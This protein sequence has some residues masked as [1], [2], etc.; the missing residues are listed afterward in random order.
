MRANEIQVR[1]RPDAHRHALSRWKWSSTHTSRIQRPRD[2]RDEQRDDEPYADTRGVGAVGVQRRGVA[3]SRAKS[4]KQPR[5]RVP[6]GVPLP[7]ASSSGESSP[8]SSAARVHDDQICRLA[9]R[10][11]ADAVAGLTQ[12]AASAV[13]LAQGRGAVLH[14][15][16]YTYPSRYT[17]GYPL[18]LEFF[19]RLR[20]GFGPLRVDV[21]FGM[22]SVLFIFMLARGCFSASLLE[23][24]LR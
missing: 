1:A 3:M 15:G 7:R 6:S 5:G 11:R 20:A 4:S 10:A 13:N 23:R 2:A 24:L 22:V 16:G 18:I 19:Y 14:F 21:F 17:A 9:A 12:Y 8:R